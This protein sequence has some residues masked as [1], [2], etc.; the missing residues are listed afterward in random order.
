MADLG[1]KFDKEQFR[2]KVLTEQVSQVLSEA[3]LD[4]T[5][6]HGEQLVET[7]L[8]KQLGISRS[9]LREAFRDLEKK[10][11]VVIIPRRGTFV[12]EITGKDVEENFPVRAT[13]EGLAAREAYANISSD[14][15]EEMQQALMGMQRAGESNDPE[16]YRRQHLLFHEIFIKA[17]G[18]DLLI[19]ML[20]TLRM[21]RLWFFVS[22]SYHRGDFRKALG[23]HEQML[24]LFASEKTDPRE[25]EFLV[26]SHIEE[27]LADFL[28]YLKQHQGLPETAG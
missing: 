16:L 18:N 9:P 24:N 6:K 12:R 17:S 27:A 8:Q 15:L 21:H 11:L 14:E 10:G 2:P 13:L 22:Y 25:L 23:V 19:E 7:D 26:R 3:I 28:G 5:L 20:G 1:D 4:G